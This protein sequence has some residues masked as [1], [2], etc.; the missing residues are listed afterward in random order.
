MY[1]ASS[2]EGA[3]DYGSRVEPVYLRVRNPLRVKEGQHADIEAA[4]QDG[5]DGLIVEIENGQFFYVVSD[6]AQIKSAIGNRGTYAL[7]DP[8]IRHSLAGPGVWSLDKGAEFQRWFGG[9]KVVD[10]DGKPL[11]L[12]HGTGADTGSEF[13]PGSFFA[14][15]PDV[16]AIYATAPTRQV[17]DGAPNISPVYLALHN[18]YVHDDLGSGENLSH[19]VL[20]RRGSLEMVREALIG[21]GYDGVVIRNRMDL[22]G[23]Q[24]QYVA[25]HPEQVKSA[26]GNRGTYDPKSPDIRHSLAGLDPRAQA[27]HDVAT[28]TTVFLAD[29]ILAGR[30]TSVFLHEIVHRHG[31]Q[32]LPEGRWGALVGQVKA[33]AKAQPQSPE[34][35]IHDAAAARVATAG[36]AGALADEELF[37]YAVE[38][39]VARGIE[40]SAAA[41]QGSAEAWLQVVVESIQRISDKLLGNDLQDL[42]GQDLVDLAYALAQLDS[43]EHGVDVRRALV[44]AAEPAAVLLFRIESRDG[45]SGQ[46]NLRLVAESTG[47]QV[48]RIDYSVYRGDPAIEMIHVDE[49]FRRLG[50]GKAMALRLQQEYPDTEVK[51]GGLTVDGVRLYESIPKHFIKD[52]EYEAKLAELSAIQEKLAAY[53]LLGET[54]D[55]IDSPTD[56]QRAS[57]MSAVGDWNDLHDTQYEL[58]RYAAFTSPGKTMLI[59]DQIRGVARTT[60]GNALNSE[61]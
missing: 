20:G 22:G 30:E 26:T 51:W 59:A 55:A 6:P 21:R 12:F 31:R 36:V 23:V 10:G 13:R 7:N 17:D 8:D 37:A 46:S 24:N 40:P 33:W 27:W 9:S 49:D 57:F 53:D 39:A 16:A 11:M 45:P 4:D 34:R 48:G 38:E 32:A 15:R 2:K 28:S 42:S 50:I 25:F 29:R 60:S 18:P 44:Q 1:F 56:E 58:Q 3:E 5:H 43:P 19:A 35:A 47:V 52:P 14:D 41:V 54:F 61:M